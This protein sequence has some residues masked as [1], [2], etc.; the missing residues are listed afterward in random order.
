M[1]CKYEFAADH[2]Y[3]LLRNRRCPQHCLAVKA[4]TGLEQIFG[5]SLPVGFCYY[6][7][8]RLARIPIGRQGLK[9]PRCGKRTSRG[10]KCLK[11]CLRKP[12]G[13]GYFPSCEKHG[14]ASHR[15]RAR[16]DGSKGWSRAKDWANRNRERAKRAAIMAEKRAALWKRMN[17]DPAP[18]GSG[19][20]SPIDE[21]MSRGPGKPLKP[22]Y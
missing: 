21:R 12:D 1:Q 13:S 20:R 9:A 14:S 3:P 2:H 16:S 17:P 7:S 11:P 22:L 6:H 10:T 19:P 8:L 18:V 5:T 15:S 4:R